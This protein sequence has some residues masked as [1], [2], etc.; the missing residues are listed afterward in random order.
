VAICYIEAA[1]RWRRVFAAAAAEAW[2]KAAAGHVIARPT[3][4]RS[5]A[6]I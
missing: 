3:L 6:R 4:L 1:A 5:K 2:T